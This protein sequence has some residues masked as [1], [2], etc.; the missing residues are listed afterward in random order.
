MTDRRNTTE[1][2]QAFLLEV[3]PLPSERA[4]VFACRMGQA[5]MPT[6]VALIVGIVVVFFGRSFFPDVDATRRPDKPAL[7]EFAQQRGRLNE[8]LQP[9]PTAENLDQVKVQLGKKLFHDPQLSANGTV[10]C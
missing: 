10:A 8:P 9:P 4:N 7:I 1:A 3:R 5:W 2:Q 6:L